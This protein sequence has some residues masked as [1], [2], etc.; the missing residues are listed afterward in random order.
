M[1]IIELYSCVV[2]SIK[3]NNLAGKLLNLNQNSIK[4]CMKSWLE[5]KIFYPKSDIKHPWTA[6]ASKGTQDNGD[7]ERYAG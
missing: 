2:F 6:A 4:N 7:L 5:N 3:G 1:A